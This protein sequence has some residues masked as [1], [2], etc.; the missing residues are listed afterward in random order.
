MSPG[1]S[2]PLRSGAAVGRPAVGVAQALGA[3]VFIPHVQFVGLQRW[4]V[5][6]RRV[7]DEEKIWPLLVRGWRRFIRAI[8]RTAVVEERG[9]LEAVLVFRAVVRQV[10]AR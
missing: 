3:R 10:P 9:Q 4:Q 2:A 1:A 8:E 5:V 6:G 7:A